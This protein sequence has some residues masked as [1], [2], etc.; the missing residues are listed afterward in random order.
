MALS[1]HAAAPPEIVVAKHAPAAAPGGRELRIATYDIRGGYGAWPAR[2][3]DR[4][5][6]VIG[7]LDADV[8]AL[9]E[10]PLGG[11]R[12]PDVLAHLRDA[13]GMHAV[14]APTIDTP[15]RRYGNAVL[16][17][18]PIRAARTLDLS[19]HAREPRG[20]LEVDIDCG[21]ST[22][23][24]VATRLGLS[25][26]ERGAQVQRLLAEFD[27]SAMPVIL[28]G[29]IDERCVRS[30]AQQALVARFRRAPAPRPFPPA[31]PG[32]W[33]DRIWVH[34]GELLIDVVVHR[35][36]RARRT[37]D[38]YPLVARL[39]APAAVNAVAETSRYGSQ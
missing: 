9:H 37:S 27:T 32:C 39:R 30:R 38:H 36:I 23:R 5:A 10:V 22:L 7:E 18:C 24:V 3:A 13:T 15:A 14:A 16:S 17:R 29:D 1:T 6:D 33:R 28:L 4:I 25:A 34:P 8:I 21:A 11:T 2:A 35:S 26:D 31:C 19:F 20:A 12:A